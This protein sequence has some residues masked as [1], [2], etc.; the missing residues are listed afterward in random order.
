MTDEKVAAEVNAQDNAEWICRHC[1]HTNPP[2]EEHCQNC[3]FHRDYDPEATPEV[4]FSSVQE[5]MQR[6]S[7]ERR[8]ILAFYFQAGTAVCSL[9]VLIT[10]IAMSIFVLQNWPFQQAYTQDANNLA[11]AVMAVDARVKLGVSLG[12]YRELLVPMMTEKTKLQTIY[13]DRPQRTRASYQKL[14]QAAEYYSLAYTAWEQNL[15]SNDLSRRADDDARSD[16]AGD[17]VKQYWN[18]AGSN[19]MLA[20][21]ELR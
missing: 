6:D 9:L 15:I 21:G 3:A 8:S 2:E 17:D 20:L 14:L 16:K 12:E 11:D 4:D 5:Q 19:L 18:R 13:S 7:D 1:Q 10:V